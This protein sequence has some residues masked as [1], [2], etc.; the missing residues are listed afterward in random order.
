LNFVATLNKLEFINSDLLT[1]SLL[2]AI[3]GCDSKPKYIIH[4]IKVRKEEIHLAPLS[5]YREKSNSIID[6]VCLNEIEA[7]LFEYK[8]GSKTIADRILKFLIGKDFKLG[9]EC[10]KRL[11]KQWGK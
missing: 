6:R 1:T 4:L 11:M 9:V 5:L 2:E 10:L 7:G 3:N 8:N